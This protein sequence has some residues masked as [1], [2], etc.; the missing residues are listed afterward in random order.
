MML[1]IRQV[2]HLLS[3]LDVTRCELDEVLENPA[4]FYERLELWDPRKPDK[5]RPVVNVTG[6]MRA[7]QTRIYRRLLLPKLTPSINSHGG[8]RGRS[9]K[10]NVTPHLGSAFCFRADISSF[11]PSIHHSRVYR[12]FAGELGCAPESREF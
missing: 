7:L 8:V 9:I 4:Q 12:L 1:N 10:T 6:Q 5:V 3:A 11:Y 2:K